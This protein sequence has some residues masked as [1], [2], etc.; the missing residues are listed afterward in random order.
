AIQD[1]FRKELNREVQNRPGYRPD[2]R[3]GQFK[4]ILEP[5]SKDNGLMTQTLK[6]KRPVIRNKYQSLIDSMY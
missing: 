4:F 6:I 1:L 3:I 5:F 2:D